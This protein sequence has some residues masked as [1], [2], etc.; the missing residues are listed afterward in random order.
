MDRAITDSQWARAIS[1][2]DKNLSSLGLMTRVIVDDVPVY[3]GGIVNEL[4]RAI[5]R[6][7]GFY[8][9]SRNSIHL[10]N[11]WLSRYLPLRASAPP[12]FIYCHEVG[13]AIAE[14]HWGLIRGNPQ[15]REAFGNSYRGKR[16]WA[17]DPDDYVTRYAM[18]SPA[19]DFA[20]TFASWVS[21]MGM[22]QGKLTKRLKA[23]YAFIGMMPRRI[24]SLGIELV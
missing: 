19:E 18:E 11:R 7:D 20:E 9:P 23:K 1:Q 12:R 6:A 21:N 5:Q 14:N 8:I 16:K 4:Y 3:Y 13:H 22:L 24:R 15:F 2:I 17:E 10:P